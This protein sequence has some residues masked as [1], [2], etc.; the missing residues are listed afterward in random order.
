MRDDGTGIGRDP[1]EFSLFE[2]SR[3]IAAFEERQ[4]K[5]QGGTHE[6]TRNPERKP[7]HG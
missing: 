4:K 1:Y 5:G 7:K 2:R 3:I 6:G